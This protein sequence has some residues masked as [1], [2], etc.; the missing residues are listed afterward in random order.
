MLVSRPLALAPARLAALA[1]GESIYGTESGSADSALLTNDAT[2]PAL[3]IGAAGRSTIVAGRL[4]LAS[5]SNGGL[6]LPR[7]ESGD[8]NGITVRTEGLTAWNNT[9]HLPNFWSGS[10]WITWPV[11]LHTSGTLAERPVSPVAGDTYRVTSGAGVG[12]QYICFVDGEWVSLLQSGARPQ[13][14]PLCDYATN[15]GPLS[16]VGRCVLDPAIYA[17]PGLTL[18]AALVVIGDVSSGGLTGTIELFDLTDAAVVATISVTSTTTTAQNAT[19]VPPGSEHL[20]EL[21]VQ[22]TGGT[23]YITLSAALRITWS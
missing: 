9:T 13:H 18:E 19:V 20:Y 22:L 12:A 21:R 15:G 5:G 8:L 14:L 4:G 3:I 2:T 6:F 7:Y 17:V 16:V 1:D 23:G 11:S 10:D